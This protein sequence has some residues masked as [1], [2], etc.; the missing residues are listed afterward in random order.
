MFSSPI[1]KMARSLQQRYRSAYPQFLKL[2][3]LDDVEFRGQLTRVGLFSG[4]SKQA[5]L[6]K[7]TKAEK[8]ELFLS[9]CIEP[10]FSENGNSNAVLEQLLTVME[11]S[12]FLPAQQLAKEI[13]GTVYKLTSEAKD[14]T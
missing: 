10:G 11:Q 7:S 4:D 2:L 12:T 5:I 1:R 8:V 6:A 14:M 3:P 9:I 13:R